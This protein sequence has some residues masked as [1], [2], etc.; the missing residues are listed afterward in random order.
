MRHTVLRE[1]VLES[2]HNTELVDSKYHVNPP[3]IYG[4]GM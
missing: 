2:T 4:G 1:T 3:D